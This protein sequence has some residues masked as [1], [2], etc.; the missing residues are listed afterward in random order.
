MFSAADPQCQPR[1]PPVTMKAPPADDQ[2]VSP[3]NYELSGQS[4]LD[5]TMK[6]RV[7]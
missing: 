1:Q 6:E 4:P 7:L 3:P 2:R 5:P